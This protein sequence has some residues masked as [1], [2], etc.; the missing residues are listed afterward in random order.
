L[1]QLSGETDVGFYFLVVITL[2]YLLEYLKYRFSIF[3][4]FGLL[5]QLIIGLTKT[6][7]G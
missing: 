2:F 3:S 1:S 4:H 5:L 6:G 7:F